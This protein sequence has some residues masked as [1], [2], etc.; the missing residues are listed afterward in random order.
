VL[1]S[2]YVL[3]RRLREDKVSL[4]H[5]KSTVKWMEDSRHFY[6]TWIARQATRRPAFHLGDRTKRKLPMLVIRETTEQF[7]NL[8]A[9]SG[10]LGPD[11]GSYLFQLYYQ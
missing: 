11:T 3:L 5:L 9:A 8:L 2:S 7:S 1:H 6:F 10:L 4:Q